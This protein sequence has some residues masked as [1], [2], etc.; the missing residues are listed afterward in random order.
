MEAERA[1][2]EE[3]R[4]VREEVGKPFELEEG[5]CCGRGWCGLEEE[6]HVLLVTMHHIVSDGWSTGVMVREFAELYAGYV[7]GEEGEAGGA[8][9]AVWGLC[10]VAA[11]VAEG[12]GAGGA[13][14]VLAG[15][16]GGTG[17]SGAADGPWEAG[18]DEPA[19]RDG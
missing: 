10:G 4:L 3:R 1:G 15:A 8:K 18:G 16:V 17:S 9:G 7:R 13:A 14:G 12:R 11:G 2:E 6:E 5:R 19:G